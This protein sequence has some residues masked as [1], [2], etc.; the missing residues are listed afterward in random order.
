MKP[1][2]TPSEKLDEM[3]KEFEQA[4][5][6]RKKPC[7]CEEAM[8]EQTIK[9]IGERAVKYADEAVENRL[10]ELNAAAERYDRANNEALRIRRLTLEDSQ[11]AFIKQVWLAVSLI[12]FLVVSIVLD[13]M[14]LMR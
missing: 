5:K 1:G 10:V 13:V 2:L 6:K 11:R 7:K 12:I 4:L 9:H 14:T 3:F 8:N